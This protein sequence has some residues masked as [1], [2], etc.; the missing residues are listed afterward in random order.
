[1][2]AKTGATTAMGTETGI[3]PQTQTHTNTNL[4]PTLQRRIEHPA[5]VEHA[6]SILATNDK[7]VAV[8]DR[9]TSVRPGIV[10]TN[11]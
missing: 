11:M 3:D 4:G 6:M 5:I 1:M 2:E 8:V 7:T 10:N 9:G